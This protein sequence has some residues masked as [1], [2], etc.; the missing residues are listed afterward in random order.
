MDLCLQDRTTNLNL[1]GT[2][3]KNLM[4]GNVKCLRL[5]TEDKKNPISELMLGNFFLIINYYHFFL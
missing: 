2:E 1:R 5:Q 4:G 3:K